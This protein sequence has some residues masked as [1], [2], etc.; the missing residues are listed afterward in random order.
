MDKET[1]QKVREIHQRI[2]VDPRFFVEKMLG[3]S[4]WQKQLDI[5]ESV[6]DNK[7]T[8]V[9]SCHASGKSWIGARVVLW[10]LMAYQDSVVLTTAPTYRQVT[11]VLWREIR[12][13]HSKAKIP[14]GGRMTKTKWEL[15]EKWFGLGLSTNDP[16]KFQGIRGERTLIVVDEAAGVDEPIFNA[17]DGILTNETSRLLLMGNPT[18]LSGRFY[19]SFRDSTSNKIHI[20]AFDTP[21][22]VA[23]SI[24]SIDDLRSEKMSQANIVSPYLISPSWA[25]ERLQEWTEHSPMFEARVLGDFPSSDDQCLIPLNKI[26]AATTEERHA[27]VDKSGHYTGLDVARFGG[28]KTVILTRNGGAVVEIVTSSKEDTM[29]TV[30]RAH[31]VLLKYPYTTV[32]TDVIGVGAGVH[33]R[34]REIAPNRVR[35]VNVA[36]SPIHGDKFV[37]LRDELSWKLRDEFMNDRIAIP[38][39]P[40]LV[41]QLANIRYRY[42]NG[43]LK[44]ESK[45]DMK[46][47]GLKSP[48]KADAL[49]LSYAPQGKRKAEGIR[50]G[51]VWQ[52]YLPD[53]W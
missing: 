40:E 14:L 9:R 10:Y 27:S 2:K 41:S 51:P 12:N 13:A 25:A 16:D 8:T 5:I 37:N 28:D 19:S 29:Q 11:E 44:I 49:M 32:C 52:E 26:E 50:W 45:D 1:E 22:F 20:S 43:K 48:D 24:A 21:N 39:D 18:S 47:R 36:T 3:E 7:T 38:D 53:G 4:S 42:L 31:M 35:A 33:D 34:L 30:G 15:S 46:K 23:S 17:I 6:R